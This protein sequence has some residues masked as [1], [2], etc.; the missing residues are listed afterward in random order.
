MV[1][2]MSLVVRAY[3][4]LG[5]LS[6]A[7][8]ESLVALAH[9]A[10]A[11][12]GRFAVA[13]AGGTTPRLLYALLANKYRE[14]IPWPQ[15]HLFWGDERCVPPDHSESNF[16][17]VSQS[18]ISKVPVPPE[19]IHR[20]PAE[21]APPE[22]AAEAYEQTL[23]ECFHPLVRE[24]SFFSFD[25]ALLGV[26]ADGHTASLFPGDPILEER[27]RWVAAVLAPPSSP[28]R[29][30]ITLTLPVIN[31]AN[32]VFFLV[33]GAG[34]RA[35]VRSILD[36]PEKA[37]KLYPAA[38]V[39]PRQQVVWFIDETTSSGQRA[40]VIPAELPPKWTP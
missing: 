37:I 28:P 24:G 20:I 1:V 21:V 36:T 40:S 33:S 2:P 14:Q 27:E 9:R 31:R 23:R 38:M 12:R 8:A 15:V 13:L 7:A 26:G 5:S 6:R 22:K 17:M 16:A 11:E 4:D 34:K 29:R 10:V 35:A 30:R 18:L 39:R 25:V 19:N 3:P 32:H